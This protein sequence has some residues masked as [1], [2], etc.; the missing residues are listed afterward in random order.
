MFYERAIVRIVRRFLFEKRS[1]KPDFGAKMADHKPGEMMFT[2]KL[3]F[4]T[5]MFEVSKCDVYHYNLDIKVI[6]LWLNI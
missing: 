5:I 3:L 6:L 2:I 4:F 1:A